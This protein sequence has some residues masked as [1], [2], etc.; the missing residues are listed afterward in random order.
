MQSLQAQPC[1]QVFFFWHCPLPGLLL[2]NC[3]I[4]LDISCFHLAR[5]TPRIFAIS[6]LENAVL[7]GRFFSCLKPLKSFLFFMSCSDKHGCFVRLCRSST[8]TSCIGNIWESVPF[9]SCCSYRDRSGYLSIFCT[10]LLQPAFLLWNAYSNLT[11]CYE[12]L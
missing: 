6:T 9:S 2:L 1:V 11:T 5:S 7:H 3:F 4:A 8:A 12:Q 10:L